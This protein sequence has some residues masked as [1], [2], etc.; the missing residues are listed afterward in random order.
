MTCVVVVAAAI[1]A[2]VTVLVCLR[3]RSKEMLTAVNVAYQSN[4]NQ[5]MIKATE[6]YDPHI[7]DCIEDIDDAY[8]HAVPPNTATMSANN[9]VL[10][11]VG[12]GEVKLES[13]QAYDSVNA[14]NIH[15][16]EMVDNA[17][18]QGLEMTQRNEDCS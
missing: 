17:A 7:Y 9:A 14:A 11:V 3:R 1:V 18:Y 13:N 5:A 15:N 10:Q 16:L 8:P 4:V 6:A 2:V 12:A